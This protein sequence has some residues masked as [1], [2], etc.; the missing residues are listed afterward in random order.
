M[1]IPAF[2]KQNHADTGSRPYREGGGAV[3]KEELFKFKNTRMRQAVGIP[4]QG[5]TT[6]KHEGEEEELFI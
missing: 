4:A 3:A 6:C 2:K 5:R 1:P